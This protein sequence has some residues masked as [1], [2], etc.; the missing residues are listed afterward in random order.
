LTRGKG[1]PKVPRKALSS[2][3]L[4]GEGLVVDPVQRRELVATQEARG[5]YVG[6]DHAFLDDPV[7]IVALVAADGLDAAI[8][9]QLDVGLRKL[10]IDGAAPAPLGEEHTKH[11]VQ[12]FEVR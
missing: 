10:E 8:L 3:N 2:L 1:T 9:A 12:V 6:R 7:R 11:V 5:G 4:S